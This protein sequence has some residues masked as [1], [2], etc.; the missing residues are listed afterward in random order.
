MTRL[1]A[2]SRWSLGAGI[3]GGAVCVLAAFV[4][5]ERFFHAY[6]FAY[7]FW[8]GIGLGALALLML[9][10]LT[11]GRWG[12]SVSPV[13]E[14]AT[15]PLPLL[16]LL[17]LPIAWGMRELYVW[18]GGNTFP[19][20]S[21]GKQVYLSNTFFLLRIVL[22]FAIW[23]ALGWSMRHWSTLRG[24][25][26]R[27]RLHGISAAGIILYLLTMTFAYA[28]L[29]MSAQ[30]HWYSTIF[31]LLIA[32]GEIL[33]G[34]AFALIARNLLLPRARWPAPVTHD[35]GNIL[36]GLVLGWAYLGF[37]QFLIIWYANLPDEIT[38]YTERLNRGFGWVALA[39]IGFHFAL[40]AILL[41]WRRLKRNHVALTSVAGV[42]LAAHLLYLFWL[43]APDAGTPALFG[44]SDLA[45]GVA[46]GGFWLSSFTLALRHSDPAAREVESG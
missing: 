7:L 19:P 27:A 2:W 40:P 17:F 1:D 11:G 10:H 36:L 46:I 35:L 45:A 37:S 21:A 34:A 18:S 4:Q 32:V 24:E 14:A 33:A 30:P 13:L 38:W 41:L 16:L 42:L 31:G 25:G 8:L 44:W 15:R 29:V 6:L 28:D 20:L 12:D 5:P 43:V 9:Y 3:A 39:V 23:I 26:N 22:Y